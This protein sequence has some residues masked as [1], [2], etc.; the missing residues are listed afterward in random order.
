MG[1]WREVF[2]EDLGRCGFCKE[3]FAAGIF[4]LV[5]SVGDRNL[6]GVPRLFQGLT[7]G[8]KSSMLSTLTVFDQAYSIEEYG[9]GPNQHRI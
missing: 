4:Q 1:G 2:D 8:V 5:L 7:F 9:D 3:I 6:E